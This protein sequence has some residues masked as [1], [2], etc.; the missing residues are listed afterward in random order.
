MFLGILLDNS[1]LATPRR[2]YS[3]LTAE[4]CHQ[5]SP[6]E[7]MR[8][9]RCNREL[10]AGHKSVV[11]VRPPGNQAAPKLDCPSHFFLPPVCLVSLAMGPPPEGALNMAAWDK[12]RDLVGPRS[13]P[14]PG[15]L[16]EP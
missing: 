14:E 11:A 5:E 2:Q 10:E 12:I 13:S 1:R 15:G 6:L 7:N 8:C 4:T 16:G 9:L 3:Y